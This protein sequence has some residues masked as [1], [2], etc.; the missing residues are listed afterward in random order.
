VSEPTGSVLLYDGLCGFCDWTV[1]LVLWADRKGI[2]RFAPLQG[3]FA[4]DVITRHPEL[5]DVDSLIL[6]E[7][8]GSDHERVR[9]RSD[10]ALGVARLLGGPWR[11]MA[12]F[13]L[14]PRPLRDW[15]YDAFARHR[16]GIFGHFD[17]CPL[18][19]QEVRS[20]FLD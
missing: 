3:P 19:P 11:L 20:R 13:A 17:A 14:V 18:P 2:V 6:V 10:G 12:I 9:V 1:R 4:S 8:A 16:Y 15:A 7:D 5:A